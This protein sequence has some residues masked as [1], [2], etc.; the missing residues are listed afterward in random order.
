MTSFM[1]AA[2]L[3]MRRM[4][5]RGNISRAGF[6][7]TG[8]T[9]DFPGR[10]RARKREIV[11]ALYIVFN[12]FRLSFPEL[13]AGDLPIVTRIRGRKLLDHS[14]PR[15]Y[16]PRCQILLLW[17]DQPSHEAPRTSHRNN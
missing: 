1:V 2:R 13:L 11:Y 8:R 16:R 7:E 10:V 12:E 3:N 6:Q 4:P 5:E 15:Q 14:N 17:F 9:I